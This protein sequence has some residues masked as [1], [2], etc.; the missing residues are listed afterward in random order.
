MYIVF[1]MVASQGQICRRVTQV[2]VKLERM[3]EVLSISSQNGPSDSNLWH[4]KYIVIPQ[5]CFTDKITAN[6]NF[7]SMGGGLFKVL[8]YK[9]YTD[10]IES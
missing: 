5:S 2:C 8:I 1:S 6:F 7:N 3:S 4:L 9:L 10:R